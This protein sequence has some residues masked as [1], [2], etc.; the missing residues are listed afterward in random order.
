MSD[1]SGLRIQY[2]TEINKN[3]ISEKTDENYEFYYI[4]ISSVTS[5]GKIIAPE[6]VKFKNAPSRAR[7]LLQ[8]GDVLISTV[9]TYLKAISSIKKVNENYVSSTGFAVLTPKKNINSS[10]LS[11]AVRNKNFIDLVCANSVGVSFPAITASD[12]GKLKIPVPPLETQK[13]IANYLDR[14]T[15]AIDALIAKKQRMIELLEE[16]RSA[17]INHVVTKG[18]DPDVPMKDSGIPWIGEIP[19]HWDVKKLKYCFQFKSGGTPSKNNLDYWQGGTIPWVSPKDM[20]SF[21]IND[22][23]DKITEL[24]LIDNAANLIDSDAILIVVRGMILARKIP[25]GVLQKSA[26]INQDMKALIPSIKMSIHYFGRQL[27]LLNLQKENLLSEAGHGTKTF[28]S[29]N[30]AS[31]NLLIP[32]YQEQE[33]IGKSIDLK[34]LTT[35]KS[36]DLLNQQV[37]KLQEY[38]QALIT[39]AVTGKIDV[40]GEDGVSDDPEEAV[41]QMKLF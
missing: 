38:R 37:K 11:Y 39:A 40:T 6:L 13:H 29:E 5:A 35:K 33:K 18:L 19:A 1:F 30:I 9:R 20:K 22:S 7:R 25:V 3:T 2:I 26:T 21:F 15:E 14:K 32:P 27:D 28:P 8:E 23:I 10:F 17:L 31:V 12:L 4:D 34:S 24:A 16:K 41:E 36:Q